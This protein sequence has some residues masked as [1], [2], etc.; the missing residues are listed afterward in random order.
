M[1]LK[2]GPKCAMNLILLG[3]SAAHREHEKKAGCVELEISGHRWTILEV[4]S[5]PRIGARPRSLYFGEL[6]LGK[7]V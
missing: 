6:S 4:I 5:D 7:K 2:I 1:W 3:A